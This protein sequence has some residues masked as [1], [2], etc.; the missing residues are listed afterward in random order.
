MGCDFAQG[1]LF[2]R[3][4]AAR[5]VRMMVMGIDARADIEEQHDMPG[6]SSRPAGAPD[7]T[8]SA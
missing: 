1:Y 6:R 4:R 8:R 5:E 7:D 2:G 3:P